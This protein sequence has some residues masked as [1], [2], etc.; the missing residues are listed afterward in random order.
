MKSKAFDSLSWWSA[1]FGVNFLFQ[2]Y[3]GSPQDIIIFTIAWILIILES[4]HYLDWIPE[5]KNLRKLQLNKYLLIGVSLYLLFTKRETTLTIW[6]FAALFVYL[7]FD[8]WRR[9][10]G[11]T[12]KMSASEIKSARAWSGIG[13]I[14][15]FWELLAF[16]L[17]SISKDDYSYPT[18]SVL[19]APHLDGLIGR[20]IFIIAWAAVGF[21][22]INDW[23]E[24]E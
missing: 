21:L 16:V 5:F 19:I 24:P 1:A 11:E 13:I 23:R 14:L 6:I 8:L 7:F 12:T 3:R 9:Q 17:A 22:I 10:D 15:C 4:T 18:I 2:I 20:G